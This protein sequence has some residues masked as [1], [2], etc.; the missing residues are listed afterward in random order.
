MTQL[1]GATSKLK[2]G[3][4]AAVMVLALCV[5]TV[6][7]GPAEAEQQ[8]SIFDKNKQKQTTKVTATQG[9]KAVTSTEVIAGNAVSPFLAPNSAAAMETAL[10]RYQAIS[11]AGGWPQ[12]GAIGKAKKGAESKGIAILNKRLFIEGYLRKEATEGEF[13]AR[14]TTATEEAVKR[15]QRNNGL[16]VTGV[17]DTATQKALNVPVSRRIATI[18]ANIPRLA[19]YTKDLG[20][21]YLV[22][23]VPAMQI[24]AV[25]GGKVFSRHNAIVGRPSRP[26]PVVQTALAT[27]KFNPYWNAPA[28]II[29]KDIIPRM[30]SGGPS[31]V[32]NEMN[33]TVFEGVG[34]PEVDP[35]EVDWRRAVADDYHFRQEP[36]G[37]NAMK[38]AK[39]EFPSPFGIYLHDTPEPH[40]FKQGNRFL[41]S[42]CVR[43]DRVEVL[44]NWILRGQDGIDQA[45]IAEL[46]GSQE[47]LDVALTDPPQLRVAYLT[48]WPTD[49]GVV[50]FRNDVYNLDGSGF[51]VGQPFDVAD[52]TGARFTLKP[53]PRSP[54]S[55][56][57]DEFQ[58]F[59][60]FRFSSSKNSEDSDKKVKTASTI[61]TT[62]NSSKTKSTGK[63]FFMSSKD[64]SKAKNETLKELASA[65]KK[66]TGKATKTKVAA[67][68]TKTGKPAAGKSTAKTAKPD[69]KKAKPATA[70]KAATTTNAKKPAAECKTG[71]DGKLPEGCKAAAKPKVKPAKPVEEANKPEEVAV[72]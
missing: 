5:T 2:S 22:V 38:T 8:N 33:I 24:E 21:R 71:K 40:L 36:G 44:L 64:Q 18:K 49:G 28:S 10:L 29:E 14:F 61:K 32:L 46:A 54:S 25:N 59:S 6:L 58:G 52:S 70:K 26:T 50:A 72:N 56:D 45:R 30:I 68:A 34:G 4:W 27:V 41:S 55:V 63:S 69:D 3:M 12:V 7:P 65:R 31:Q 48:A 47:R 53:I 43:V 62:G 37:A 15:F 57:A 20:D 23:N 11:A 17:I 60:L 13:A 35:D 39:I 67:K 19:E 1:H 66:V 51:V 16:A 42:G 9:G